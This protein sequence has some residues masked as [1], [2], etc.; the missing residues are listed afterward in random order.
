MCRVC[1]QLAHTHSHTR[2]HAHTHALVSVDFLSKVWEFLSLVGPAAIAQQQPADPPTAHRAR[3]CAPIG[4]PA[5]RATPRCCRRCAAL[6]PPTTQ[7]LCP[8][9]IAS[10]AHT[11]KKAVRLWP[12]EVQRSRSEVQQQRRRRRGQRIAHR[13]TKVD[14]AAARAAAVPCAKAL[15]HSCGPLARV[16]SLPAEFRCNAAPEFVEW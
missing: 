2:T 9:S 10:H 15:A 3:S 4:A 12:P 11:H 13:R 8:L 6:S 5:L 1:V 16:R 14:K 7:A